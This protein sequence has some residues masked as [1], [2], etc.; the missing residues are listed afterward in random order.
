M[1][2]FRR[3]T[4]PDLVEVLNYDQVMEILEK[5]SKELLGVSG[6]EAMAMAER[7][8]IEDTLGGQVVTSWVMM[9]RG[10]EAAHS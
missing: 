1:S 6:D 7:G 2:W 3:R 4:T 8:E 10:A 5:R 9:A